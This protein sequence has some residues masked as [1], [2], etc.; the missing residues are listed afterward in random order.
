MTKEDQILEILHEHT[1]LLNVCVHTLDGH[2]K[3]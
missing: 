2:T 1:K 3:L